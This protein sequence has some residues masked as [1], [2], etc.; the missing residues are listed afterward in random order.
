MEEEYITLVRAAELLGWST[1]RVGKRVKAHKIK[2]RDDEADGRTKL[3]AT[4]DL[5]RL[6]GPAVR[7]A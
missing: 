3:I 7:P 6:R 4:A 1:R 2:T 5:E